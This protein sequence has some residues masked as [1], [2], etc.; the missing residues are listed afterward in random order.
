MEA[1]TQFFRRAMGFHGIPQG[2]LPKFSGESRRRGE[3]TLREWLDEFDQLTEPLCLDDKAKARIMVDHLAG[4]AKDE[5]MC[6]PE[7]KR[8]NPTDVRKALQLCF[9]PAETVQSLSALF[10]NRFQEDGESLADFS[11][12]LIRIYSRMEATAPTQEDAG[13]LKQLRDGT[14][15]EQFVRGAREAWVKRE[16]RR[17]SIAP[18]TD[19]FEKM[20]EEA[21]LLFQD[22]PARK[23]VVRE[24]QAVDP[25][26][27]IKSMAACQEKLLTEITELKNEVSALRAKTMEIDELRKKIA[28]LEGNVQKSNRPRRQHGRGD[29]GTR[30]TRMQD[31][32]QGR[33]LSEVT[34]YNCQQLGHYAYNCPSSELDQPIPQLGQQPFLVPPSTQGQ[35][36]NC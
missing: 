30:G 4:A 20:R 28:Q 27:T 29:H 9:T 10:H 16:L 5:V 35:Q 34:C 18:T 1:M 7:E 19:N 33:S 12:D 11:R 31:R 6:L 25:E 26:T 3:L 8:F 32:S 22:L 21:I 2:K 15:K 36:G 13:A 24:V 14:L 17:I 23:A